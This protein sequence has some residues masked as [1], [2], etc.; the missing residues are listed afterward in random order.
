MT[1]VNA[2]SSCDTSMGLTPA[3]GM[4]MACRSGDIDPGLAWRLRHDH[5]LSSAQFNHM[6]NRESGLQGVSGLSGDL[7]LLLECE[8]VEAGAADAL[9]MFCYQARKQVCAMAAA[10]EG[11]ET[12]VFSGGA[13]EHLATLRTRICTGLAFLGIELDQALNAVHAPIISTGRSSV[14]VRVIHTD[15][16]WMIAHEMRNLLDNSIPSTSG[17]VVTPASENHAEHALDEALTETFPSSDPVAVA[18]QVPSSRP[19]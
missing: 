17:G 16:Q 8:A 7:R 15:E 10:L 6:V 13:G 12:L 3:G 1:A 5:Q 2:G 19:L 18:I 9:A 4:M 11:I 14:A